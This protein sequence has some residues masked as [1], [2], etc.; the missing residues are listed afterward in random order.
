[1]GGGGCEQMEETIVM[2][3]DG[4]KISRRIEEG[5]RRWE[6]EGVRKCEEEIHRRRGNG[7]VP[8]KEDDAG[9]QLRDNGK[10]RETPRKS[11]DSNKVSQRSEEERLLRQIEGVSRIRKDGIVQREE[12]IIV[13]GGHR[14]K[15][16]SGQ[17]V[18]VP[19]PRKRDDR[20]HSESHSYSHSH[21]KKAKS[22]S[23]AHS[24]SKSQSQPS[25]TPQRDGISS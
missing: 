12:V 17:E 24:H 2:K 19:A 21:S 8:R 9:Q 22:H 1:M 13:E 5:L 10:R 4:V 23:H 11:S 18:P 20:S 6:E 14:R 3:E 16:S 15:M 25:T 7:M